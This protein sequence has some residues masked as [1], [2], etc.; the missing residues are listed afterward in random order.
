MREQVMTAR[1]GA[2]AAA[3][4]LALSALVG[5]SAPAQAADEQICSHLGKRG[6]ACVPVRYDGHQLGWCDPKADGHRVYVRYR[7]AAAGTRRRPSPMAVSAA[8]TGGSESGRSA[9]SRC[10]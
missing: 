1:V 8:G 7:T 3:G 6:F 2:L 9:S 4:V 10:A 5:T